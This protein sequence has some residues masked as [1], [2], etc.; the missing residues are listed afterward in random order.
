MA[1]SISA[2]VCKKNDAIPD[3]YVI[4]IFSQQRTAAEAE[5]SAAAFF[6]LVSIW[7][8]KFFM[9][10]KQANYLLRPLEYKFNIFFLNYRKGKTYAGLVNSENTHGRGW[11]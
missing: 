11:Y 6:G 2:K 3:E 4:S 9:N 8:T 7:S 1:K 10:I 5:D